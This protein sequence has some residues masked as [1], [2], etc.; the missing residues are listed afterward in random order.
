MAEAATRTFTYEQVA[1][2]VNDGADLVVLGLAGLGDME[3]DLI[4]LVVNAA[5]TKLEH[6]R[7]RTLDG[8][9]RVNYSDSPRQVRSWWDWD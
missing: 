3:H 7:T 9:I 8:V 2:A 1:K 6:P 5:L 4:N